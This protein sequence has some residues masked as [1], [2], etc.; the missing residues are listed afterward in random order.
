[1]VQVLKMCR[2]VSSRD[3]EEEYRSQGQREHVAQQGW[4]RALNRGKQFSAEHGKTEEA[5]WGQFR[6]TPNAGSSPFV[7]YANRL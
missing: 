1:M 3:R 7:L 2:T 6:Q 4:R 5:K